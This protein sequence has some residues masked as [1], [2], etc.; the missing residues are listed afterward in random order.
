MTPNTDNPMRAIRGIMISLLIE[1][2]AGGVVYLLIKGVRGIMFDKIQEVARIA[3]GLSSIVIEIERANDDF[4]YVCPDGRFAKIIPLLV[5]YNDVNLPKIK[6]CNGD[7]R[8]GI[9]FNFDI[10]YIH[11]EKAGNI[12]KLILE[13]RR[14]FKR[15]KSNPGRR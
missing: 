8:Y 2:L 12:A 14:N 5:K 15:V 10:H 9:V 4:V 6:P 7:E 13:Y 3:N 11:K 1:A